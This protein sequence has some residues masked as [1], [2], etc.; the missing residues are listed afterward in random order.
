MEKA[1]DLKNLE[2]RLKAKGLVA[3]EGLAKII[4]SEVLDWCSESCL[5]DENVFVK[6]VGAPAVALL[7]PIVMSAVDKIDSIE[8]D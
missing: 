1:F 6:A 7:R 3:V 5:V 4:A 8:G 2:D